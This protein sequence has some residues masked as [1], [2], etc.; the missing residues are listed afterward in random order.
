M[1]VY[2]SDILSQEGIPI[3]FLQRTSSVSSNNFTSSKETSQEE[4]NE[5]EEEEDQS[6][7]KTSVENSAH[8]SQMTSVIEYS[9]TL[10]PT[11][12]LL[13]SNMI[14]VHFSKD[15]NSVYSSPSMNSH[16]STHSNIPLGLPSQKN[17][18]RQLYLDS[19]LI[20]DEPT[21]LQEASMFNSSSEVSINE[22][23]N[24]F[25]EVS[26]K[27][28]HV[29]P[30]LNNGQSIQAGLGNGVTLGDTL[31][32]TKQTLERDRDGKRKYIEEFVDSSGVDNTRMEGMVRPATLNCT[33]FMCY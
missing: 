2:P 11:D 10:T 32:E 27:H 20:E 29:S 21:Q 22:K 1:C 12:K 23:E 18:I 15:D 3:Q 26:G 14:P 8:D 5:E 33:C 25:H 30:E 16:L 28:T 31:T 7:H 9:S 17:P 24:L 4:D 19:T 6:F 13:T